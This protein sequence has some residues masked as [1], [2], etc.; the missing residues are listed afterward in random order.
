M[1]F[2]MAYDVVARSRANQNVRLLHD[3]DGRI[4]R[5]SLPKEETDIGF[6]DGF[7]AAP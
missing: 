5:A 1:V 2:S 6:F 4:F 3:I 7:A